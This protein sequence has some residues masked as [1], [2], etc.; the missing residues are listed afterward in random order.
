M[1]V[2]SPI[3]VDETPSSKH[4]KPLP[5]KEIAVTQV[6]I[7]NV[8]TDK[9]AFLLTFVGLEPKEF[10]VTPGGGAPIIAALKR[11][12]LDPQQFYATPWEIH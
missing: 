10:M 2:G 9:V 7:R 3:D 11:R 1:F 5:L 6:P 8:D 12:G 4:M